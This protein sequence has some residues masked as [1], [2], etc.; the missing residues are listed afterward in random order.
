MTVP[1]ETSRVTYPGNGA[2][3]FPTTF[4]FQ[5]A[6]DLRITRT[7]GGV[8]LVLTEGV[9]YAVTLPASVGVDGTVNLVSAL[10][11]GESLTIER[12]VE[13][14]Q[15]T[16]FR[17]AGTFL[18]DVHEDAMDRLMFA[19][20]EMARRISDL[21]SAGA[22]GSVVAGNGLS[23]AG[24]TLNVGAGS[25]IQANA[26]TVEV[27]YGVGGDITG[28]DGTSS[29][30][31][32][33]KAAR[34]DH[35]HDIDFFDAPVDLVTNAANAAGT[36]GA[37][38]R[39]DHVHGVPVGAPVTVDCALPLI[40]TSGV[41]ADASHKHDVATAVALELTDAVSA[42]GT[43]MEL[44]RADHTHAHGAR[45]GGT[46]HAEATT[47]AA[48]F[49]SAAEKALM[50]ALSEASLTTTD[51]VAHTLASFAPTNGK[52]VGILAIVSAKDKTSANSASYGL[53]A[54][55][56]RH[57]GV[58]TLTGAVTVLWAHEDVVGW[59]ATI[60]VSTPDVRVRVTGVGGVSV[61]WKVRLEVVAT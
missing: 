26:D 4:Y 15:E 3:S 37:V 36:S 13:L 61:D 44:A 54:T 53:A 46:L 58:T 47:S 24:T 41:F 60:D 7:T 59:D 21:E 42:E 34:A 43:A 10:A 50:A 23:F 18:P 39:A 8:P 29:A 38:A 12:D 33:N 19:I 55:A 51:G 14:K 32:L 27:L 31:V 40:G 11:V 20:Q 49:M 22:P 6:A 35:R 56:K 45:A 17:V 57:G 28:Y 30:G 52:A 16:S 5:R 25:G 2:S 1:S 9:H 48:G